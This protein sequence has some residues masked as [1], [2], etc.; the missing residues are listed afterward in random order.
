MKRNYISILLATLLCFSCLSAPALAADK[1]PK[2]PYPEELYL[3]QSRGGTCTICSAA[4]MLRAYLWN[5][6]SDA[7]LTVSESDAMS[8]GWCSDGLLWSWSYTADGYT[9]HVA[10]ASVSGLSVEDL[11]DILEDHPEGIALYCGHQPHAVYVTNVE[12]GTV[13]CADPATG[14]W[15]PLTDSVL[16]YGG[17]DAI[18]QNVTAY[19]YIDSVS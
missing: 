9:M 3:T 7:A 18:L 1:T 15:T 13:Y 16:N 14:E 5:E 6:D 12:H 8:A 10:H 2:S 4:M 19:W 17:Q 11:E